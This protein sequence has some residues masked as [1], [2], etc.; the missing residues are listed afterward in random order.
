MT[1]E[2]RLAHAFLS[3][4]PAEAALALERM[5]VE[6][7][8]GIV[9]Q[10][11][12][13]VAGV[14]RHLLASS[15]AECLSRLTPEEAARALDHVPLD[16]TVALLRRLPA[17][18]AERI[19]GALAAETQ[20][21][22]RGVLRYPEGTAASIMDPGV[23]ALPDDI[24]AGEARVRL[25]R[26]ARGLLHYLFVVNRARTLVGVL[27]IPELMRARSRQSLRSVMRDP[28]ERVPAWTPATAVRTHPGWRSFHAMPVTDEAGRLIGAIRYQTL[29][30]LEQEAEGG[31][32]PGPAAMTVSALGELF[33]LG[34]AGLIEGV[35][36]AAA[37]RGPTRS[38]TGGGGT[39]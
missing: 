13:E 22:V 8:A 31:Q 36:A 34:L 4:R 18:D 6:D 12:A 29:R 32:G 24:T 2:A 14:L 16:T 33:H 37:P 26:D 21:S 5:P 17:A 23:F 20:E 1:L 11:P 25:R 28:V 38:T 15:A 7:R 30:R 9:R 35:A 3:E 27:D 39:R 19:V 10:A